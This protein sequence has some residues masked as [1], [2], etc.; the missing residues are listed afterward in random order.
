MREL[1]HYILQRSVPAAGE[2]LAVLNGSVLEEE[3]LNLRHYWGVLRKHWRLITV[4]SLS[5]VLATVLV[6]FIITPLYTAETSLLI[7]RKTPQVL[8]I[9][10]VLSEPLTQDE[11]DFYK[12]QYEI[13]KSRALA[14]QV[15]QE[16]RL[17]GNSFF[18]K[19]VRKQ[20]TDRASR[21]TDGER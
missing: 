14:A 11:Y 6:I 15:I 20:R 19:R 1:S 5:T 16:Q 10:E 9:R 8:D 3:G 7:E 4:F 12:T 13:L 21:K 18:A 17:E 2:E